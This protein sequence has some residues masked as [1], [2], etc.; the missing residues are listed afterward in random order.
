MQI[1]KFDDIELYNRYNFVLYIFTK[2]GGI[3]YDEIF[4]KD[5]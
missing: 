1:F 4:S 3:N 2:E 5:G